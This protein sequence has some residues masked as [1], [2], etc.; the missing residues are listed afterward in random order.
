MAYISALRCRFV[1]PQVIYSTFLTVSSIKSVPVSIDFFDDEN[2]SIDVFE[3]Q[4]LLTDF[5]N[6]TLVLM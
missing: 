6:E 3:V 4:F 1:Y 2:T 5:I